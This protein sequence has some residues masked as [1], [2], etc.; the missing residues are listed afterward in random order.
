MT[1]IAVA[2]T[3]RTSQSAEQRNRKLQ[4]QAEHERR[5]GHRRERAGVEDTADLLLGGEAERRHERYEPVRRAHAP[6]PLRT[7]QTAIAIRAT[8]AI[9]PQ[10]AAQAYQAIGAC[11]TGWAWSCAAGAASPIRQPVRGQAPRRDE[12][13]RRKPEGAPEH[14]RS[15][16]RNGFP[17][18]QRTGL[19]SPEC[20]SCW[21][22]TACSTC[23]AR[24]S[25]ARPRPCRSC[26]MP[27]SRCASSRTTP[28]SRGPRSWPCSKASGSPWPRTRSRPRGVAAAQLLA[29]SRVFPLTVRAI[30]DDLAEHVELVESDAD[31]VLVGGADEDGEADEMFAWPRLNAAFGELERGA[32]LVCLHR[33]R[34]WQTAHGPL[35]DSGAVVAGLEY[36]AGVEA[37]LVGKPSA[38]Y[39]ET[40]LAALGRRAGRHDDGGRRPRGGSLHGAEAGAAR[41]P[42][43]HGEV[44]RGRARRRRSASRT[45]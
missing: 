36:A 24:S 17:H 34:W 44:P 20:P 15:M 33:N 37:E 43:P 40:A 4:Q 29:G 16:V 21:T 32:R 11:E 7:F 31:V 45:P 28:S 22:S 9:A 8:S 12:R 41:R 6:T 42:R 30:H 25:R 14:A 18:T 23:P 3:T 10:S 39:F 13:K 27:A 1:A 19:D 26:A 2:R 5:L 38:A 35:L